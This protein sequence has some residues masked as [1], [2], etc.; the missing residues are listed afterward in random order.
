MRL[1]CSIPSRIPA[2]LF[3]S[4]QVRRC[5]PIGQAQVIDEHLPS[6]AVRTEFLNKVVCVRTCVSLALWSDSA[7]T[8]RK[9][10]MESKVRNDW[11]HQPA[12]MHF[13]DA[14]FNECVIC[15]DT[16]IPLYRPMTSPKPPFQS[17]KNAQLLG[18]AHV[19]RETDHR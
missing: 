2:F 13:C 14:N 19:K 18:F 4:V 3:R 1:P 9:A 7:R 6:L 15:R 17:Q 10:C 11:L 8:S 16:L 5:Q 12:I